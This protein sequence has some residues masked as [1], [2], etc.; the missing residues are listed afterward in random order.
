MALN[1]EGY[2]SLTPG[3]DNFQVT[4]GLLVGLPIGLLALEGNDTVRGA[5]DSEIINGNIGEDLLYGGGGGDTLYGGKD[6]DGVFGEEGNIFCLRQSLPKDI[7][8][9]TRRRE[10]SSTCL[11]RKTSHSP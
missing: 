6:S 10:P 5:S 3:N 11:G 7:R 4:P 8:K 2:Y 1:P 9:V